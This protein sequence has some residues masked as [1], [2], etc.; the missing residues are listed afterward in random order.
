MSTPST[1]FA[2][3]TITIPLPPTLVVIVQYVSLVLAIIRDLLFFVYALLSGKLALDEFQNRLRVPCASTQ[4]PYET[5]Q[6]T[7]SSDDVKNEEPDKKSTKDAS[8]ANGRQD[9]IVEVPSGAGE[10][11]KKHETESQPWKGSAVRELCRSIVM[12]DFDH[13]FE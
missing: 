1:Q 7:S 8:E 12:K 2:V 3:Q 5:P 11:M 4:P 6:A 13:V 10:A 9:P